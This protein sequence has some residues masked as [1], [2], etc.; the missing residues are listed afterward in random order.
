MMNDRLLV[1]FQHDPAIVSRTIAGEIVLV[2][3]R[4]NVGDLESIY[5]MNDSGARI[6]E[7]LDGQRNLEQV[8]QQ[9]LAEFDVDPTQAETDLL[10]L[11]DHLLEIGAIV[12]V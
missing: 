12:Q 10:E 9:V 2:P 4:K 11:V 6:W 3:I 5:T 7:L 8:L 1:V